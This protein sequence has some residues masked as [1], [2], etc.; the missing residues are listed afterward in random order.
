MKATLF[1]KKVS[2][3]FLMLFIQYLKLNAQEVLYY[4]S[5]P[6]PAGSGAWQV[7]KKNL[8][9]G[10]I[11]TITN[12]QLYNYWWAQLSP[13]HHQLIMLRSPYSSSID[14]FDY[15]NCEMIKAN[16][17]GTNERV[18]LADNQY[19]WFAFGNPHWHPSGNRILMIA[20]PTNSSNPFYV[21]TIDTAGNNPALLIARWSIDA[22]WSPDGNKIV[23]IGID[24][25]G[26][27]P[28]NFEVFTADYNYSSDTVSNIHQL[29]SDTTRN[30]DP[31]FSPDG[32]HIAFSASDSAISNA[33]I[34]TIDTSGANRTSVLD[35]N[36]VHGG[37]LNWG[38]DGKIYH[39]SIYLYTTDFT[40]NAFNT[41]TNTYETFFSS[42]THGYISPYYAN[43]GA[44]SITTTMSKETISVYPNPTAT[45]INVVLPFT[46]PKF[47][48][49]IYSLL[50]QQLFTTSEQTVIN[51]SNFK[52]G[53]YILSVKQNEQIFKTKLVK[54]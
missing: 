4:C 31:C 41:H 33:D 16:A 22:N 51:I 34:V 52:N 10:T 36:G 3:L 17:D 28:K 50:G 21:V 23:F 54:Q 42:P 7:Y 46:N 25:I 6:L 47:V 37:P 49:E 35:D 29:T 27:P 18:I 2:I 12:N 40:A 1:I 19:N 24:T 48:I 11:D 44:T 9:A 39:H 32:S 53:V 45:E 26:S 14:Q 38:S 8:T 13:D 20:Q 15:A 43:L 5:R 30:H